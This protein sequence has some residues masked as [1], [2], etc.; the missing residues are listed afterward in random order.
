MSFHHAVAEGCYQPTKK[1]S[2]LAE[3]LRLIFMG[4]K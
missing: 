4:R 2:P 3:R 1:C